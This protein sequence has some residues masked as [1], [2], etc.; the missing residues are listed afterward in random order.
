MRCGQ[1][2]IISLAQFQMSSHENKKSIP[3]FWPWCSFRCGFLFSTIVFPYIKNEL[4]FSKVRTGWGSFFEPASVKRQFLKV[5]PRLLSIP[6]KLLWWC[7][8]LPSSVHFSLKLE[9]LRKKNAMDILT[10]CAFFATT[11]KYLLG[12]LSVVKK[13]V[14]A[15]LTSHFWAASLIIVVVMTLKHAQLVLIASTHPA[16]DSNIGTDKGSK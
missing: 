12:F 16:R 14:A 1:N 15:S 10:F 7:L 13:R 6:K 8:H 4:S 5:A 11:F 2:K 3:T 9:W